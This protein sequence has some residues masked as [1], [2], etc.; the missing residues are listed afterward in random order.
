M[1]VGTLEPADVPRWNGKDVIDVEDLNRQTI[2]SP[3]KIY[4]QDPY[5]LRYQS[6]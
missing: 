5:P 6:R 3:L 2:I 1:R 4:D